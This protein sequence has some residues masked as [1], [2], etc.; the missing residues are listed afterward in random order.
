MHCNGRQFSKPTQR[1]LIQHG[2]QHCKL[3][4][5][6]EIRYATSGEKTQA[7]HSR[8]EVVEQINITIYKVLASSVSSH[9]NDHDNNMI[10][11]HR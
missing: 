11:N 8:W 1:I 7:S 9:I 5:A 10:D 3:H 2:K 4:S 6:F